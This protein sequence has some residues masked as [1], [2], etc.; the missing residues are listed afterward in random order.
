MHSVYFFLNLWLY[1]SLNI[2]TASCGNFSKIK[3]SRELPDCTSDTYEIG[4]V[5]TIE[6]ASSA[7]LL[8]GSSLCVAKIVRTSKRSCLSRSD[9]WVLLSISWWGHYNI[10]DLV[11]WIDYTEHTSCWL[12]LDN[13]YSEIL[14]TMANHSDRFVEMKGGMHNCYSVYF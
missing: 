4:V 11:F 10:L 14:S 2:L 9:W 13:R 8:K 12:R 5:A 1:R 7:C 6:S 3:P